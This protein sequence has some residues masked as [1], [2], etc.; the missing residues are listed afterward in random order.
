MPSVSRILETALYAKDLSAAVAFYQRVF[1]FP[2]L[3][4]DGRLHAFDVAGQSVLL[5][6]KQGDTNTPVHFEGGVIPPHDAQGDLHF[7]FA[8]QQNELAAWQAHLAELKIPIESTVRWPRGGTSIYFRDPD[9][10]LVELAT[11]GIWAS[12]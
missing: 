12:Y 5:L 4:G 9:N 6:F 10:H 8:I 11:P 2:T 7:A 3:T 1:N